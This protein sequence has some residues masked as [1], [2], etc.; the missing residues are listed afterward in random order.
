MKVPSVGR[1]CN[2]REYSDYFVG[3]W[4]SDNYADYDVAALPVCM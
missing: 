4:R 2:F 1:P 3:Y